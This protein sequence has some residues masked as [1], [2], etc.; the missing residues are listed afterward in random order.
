MVIPSDIFSEFTDHETELKQ[1][2]LFLRKRMPQGKFQLVLNHDRGYSYGENLVLSSKLRN[3]I[4][5]HAQQEKGIFGFELNEKDFVHAIFIQELNAVLIF[6]LIKYN[7]DSFIEQYEATVIHLCI[8][9]FLS[10]LSLQNEQDF[11]TTLR[12]QYDRKITV[13]ENKY[14]EILEDNHRGYQI[15]Q[16]QQEKYSQTLKSEIARQTAQLRETN[17]SL[18][19]ARE[20]AE[21]ANKAKSHFLANMSHEIRTPMNGIIGFTE[22]LLDT[23]LSPNQIDYVETIQRSGDSLLSLIN[24]ILDFSKIEA[25]QLKFEDTEFDPELIAYD[26]CELTLPK[27]QSKPVEILC[28]IGDHLPSLVKGDPLRFQQVLTNLMGNS[29]KFTESGEIEL[30]IDA[31]DE[32]DTQVK[33]HAKVIDTGIGIQK[34]KLSTIFA[35]FKQADDSTTRKYGGTGLGLSICKQISNRMGGD[36]WAES[37]VNSELDIENYRLRDR[38]KGL[39]HYQPSTY[40]RPRDNKPGTIFHFTAWLEKSD[41]NIDPMVAPSTLSGKRVLV[42]DDNLNSLSI[43]TKIL[44]SAGM[45]VASVNKG[46]DALPALQIALDADNPI[47]LC[48]LD[49][50]MPVM[51]GYE[52]A[53]QIRNVK[54]SIRNLPLIALSF[55]L[56]HEK[57]K[58]NKAGFDDFLSKPVRRK[59]LYQVLENVLS[60]QNKKNRLRDAGDSRTPKHVKPPSSDLIEGKNSSLILLAED[61][62]INQKLAKM[63]LMK[64]GYR[65]ETA[66]TGK[67]AVDKFITS[68]GKFDLIFMDMQMPEM[69]GIEATHRI[70]EWE[71]RNNDQGQNSNADSFEHNPA[72]F[73]ENLSIENRQSSI[74]RVPIVALT[75]N[76]IKGDKEKCLA[77]GMD[78][79]ITKPI[80]KKIL[81][82]VTEKWISGKKSSQI[83][84][85]PD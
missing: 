40:N 15:I 13:L 14:Q 80:N 29:V 27:V 51:N 66:D 47:D 28:H 17:L 67:N 33:I 37:P 4:V 69:D 83:S 6:S 30:F 46:E 5:H 62:P 41:R 73:Q 38:F 55:L 3:T 12:K 11:L 43:L 9:L 20:I 42:V 34:D 85:Q 74:K 52:I 81:F 82:E 19:Q 18:K 22:M 23:N 25:G 59:K 53:K 44:L 65:V 26:I 76:A 35:P 31:E 1:F 54:S 39:N 84:I 77:S 72:H 24:D 78:D 71:E 58:D 7:S 70:R 68:S 57:Q 50:K 10:H 16:Q 45:D 8:E 60:K 32:N 61:N 36:V 21:N 49:I 48:I 63:M 79:Y 2:L 75:A 64:A 56:N